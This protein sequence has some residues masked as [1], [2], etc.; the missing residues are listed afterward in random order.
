MAKRAHRVRRDRQVGMGGYG[1]RPD[2]LAVSSRLANLIKSQRFMTLWRLSVNETLLEG[3]AQDLQDVAAE[4]RQFIQ[5]EHP[6]VRQ[7]PLAGHRH[8]APANQP[9]ARDRVVWG[10]TGARRDARRAGTGEPGHAM[11]ARGVDAF[12]EA[13]RQVVLLPSGVS[14]R[15]SLA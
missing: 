4:L 8:L 5:K 2:G 15:A 1:T 3:L 6:V 9:H 11:D 14:A 13:Q 12:G 7:R 10:A